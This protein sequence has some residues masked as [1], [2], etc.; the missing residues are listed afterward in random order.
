MPNFCR[1]DYWTSATKAAKGDSQNETNLQ[2]GLEP[3]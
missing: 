2:V 1:L 3:S